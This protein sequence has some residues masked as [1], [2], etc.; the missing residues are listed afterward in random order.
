MTVDGTGISHSRSGVDPAISN[1]DKLVA[2]T[3]LLGIGDFEPLDFLVNTAQLEQELA[4]FSNDWVDY[5]PRTDRPNNRK[6][7]SLTTLDIEGWDHRSLP[8][9]PEAAQALGRP[10]GDSAFTKPTPLYDAC[11]SLHPL[12][13]EF[14]PV[15]RSFFVKCDTGGYF[16]PH[17]D[18]PGFPRREFRLACFVKNVA[19]LQYD[20][21]MDDK[22]INIEQGRVY[23]VNTKKTHRTISWTDDSI[24]LIMNIPFTVANVNK[25]IAH[26]QHRH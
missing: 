8:S 9:L 17:R 20:W 7:L 12:F 6:G 25:V 18:S 23:Y 3:A 16:V 19:P 1:Y 22:K 14:A 24:H 10:V 2:E 21:W 15:G 4:V 11:A 26:L 13:Q 5:L